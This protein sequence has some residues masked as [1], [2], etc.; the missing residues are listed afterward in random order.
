MPRTSAT[1]P[2]TNIVF[3]HSEGSPADFLHGSIN[4]AGQPFHV[5][6]VRLVERKVG[7][8]SEQG[9]PAKASPEAE[10][11]YADIL[12]MNEG[13]MK[14]IKIRGQSGDWAICVFPHAD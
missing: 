8:F 12:S 4:I 10:A 1:L 14:T 9:L 6:A 5:V 13:Y 3:D 11:Y 7:G 2:V